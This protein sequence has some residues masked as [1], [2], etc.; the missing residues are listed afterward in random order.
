MTPPHPPLAN[1]LRT[2]PD[3]AGR[4]GDYGGRFHNVAVEADPHPVA[5][6]VDDGAESRG[7]VVDR[8]VPA[9]LLE[10]ARPARPDPL[11]RLGQPGR[12][13][14]GHQAHE[15]VRR[16]GF[17]RTLPFSCLP[18]DSA[19]LPPAVPSCAGLLEKYQGKL[20]K[21]PTCTCVRART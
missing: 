16:A 9:D 2:M 3:A 11:Q 15:L 14:V 10:L 12:R 19:A 18:A 7:D 13:G 5:V 20:P 21:L 1:S 8:L 4:F 6:G 17:A